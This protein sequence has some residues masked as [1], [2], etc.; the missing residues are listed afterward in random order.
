MKGHQ[1]LLAAQTV[2]ELRYG[3]LLARWST[4]RSRRLEGSVAATSVVPVD[5]ELITRVAQ[6]RGD[7]RT[8]AH[9]LAD[10]VHANDL[11]IAATAPH[12]QVPLLSADTI[13]RDAP[14]LELL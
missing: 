8:A 5:E 12:L 7:S 11:W 6:L 3:A 2:G 1:V 4:A 13:F 10:R 14:G 9:P